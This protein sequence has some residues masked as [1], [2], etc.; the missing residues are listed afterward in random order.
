LTADSSAPFSSQ[1]AV[2]LGVAPEGSKSLGLAQARVSA[3]GIFRGIG[4]GLQGHEGA[5]R[6]PTRQQHA[7]LLERELT[8]DTRQ[9]AFQQVVHLRAEPARDHPEHTGGGLAHPVLDLVQERA[10]EV[11]AADLGQAHS[12]LLAN[13]AN[14]LPERLVFRH[15][16]GKLYR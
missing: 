13:A 7:A 10:A 1:H 2:R 6:V 3:Q 5:A 14:S 12:A 11:R 8:L 15:C 4:G 9:A 16:K